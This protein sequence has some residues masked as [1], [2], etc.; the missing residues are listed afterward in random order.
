MVMLV[1]LCMSSVV[2]AESNEAAQVLLGQYK[3]MK[4]NC[5]AGINYYDYSKLY[6]ELYV[7]TMKQQ[8]NIDKVTFDKFITPLRYYEYA[9]T[10]W[11]KLYDSKSVYNGDVRQWFRM[12]SEKID[13]IDKTLNAQQ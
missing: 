9:P 3:D 10:D 1:T 6:R 7:A 13:E 2:H 11:N 4:L 5:E 12:A 8:G